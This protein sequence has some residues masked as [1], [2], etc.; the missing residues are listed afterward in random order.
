MLS[1]DLSAGTA[2][3]YVVE[4]VIKS[5]AWVLAPGAHPALLRLETQP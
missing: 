1:N 2:E 4:V 3:E 5:G